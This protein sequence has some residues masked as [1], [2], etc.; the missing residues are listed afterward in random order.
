MGLMIPSI[1]L[2]AVSGTAAFSSLGEDCEPV[3]LT[4]SMGSVNILISILTGVGAFLKIEE[5]IAN[6]R[7]AQV[8]Y[9]KLIHKIDDFLEDVENHDSAVEKEI[10][11]EYHD[12]LQSNIEIS[13]R[14]ISAFE[15]YMNA[16]KHSVKSLDTLLD[17]M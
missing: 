16:K 9:M 5:R 7:I 17:F 14:S 13:P 10:R 8:S 6:H 2:S 1:I 12:L 3:A 11:R 4:I 15:S